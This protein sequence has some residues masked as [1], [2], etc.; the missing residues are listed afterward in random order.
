MS[1]S[2]LLPFGKKYAGRP[3]D[4]MKTKKE[5]Q[6]LTWI[7]QTA[8]GTTDIKMLATANAIRRENLVPPEYK[9]VV[10]TAADMEGSFLVPIGKYK[11]WRLCQ[12]FDKSYIEWVMSLD[13]DEDLFDTFKDAIVSELG[14]KRKVEC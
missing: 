14:Y 8:D 11:G 2:F 3:I 1:S 12:I 5:R 9:P 10:I 6:F 13:E 4:S 7:L